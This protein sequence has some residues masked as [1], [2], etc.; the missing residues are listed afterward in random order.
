MLGRRSFGLQSR[1]LGDANGNG[2]VVPGVDLPSG[3]ETLPFVNLNNTRGSLDYT[4]TG[5]YIDTGVRAT[6]ELKV[7]L[8]AKVD[9]VMTGLNWPT[10]L[11]AG[12]YD[13]SPDW[14]QLRNLHGENGPT[15]AFGRQSD[16]D[17]RLLD[18]DKRFDRLEISVD[19]RG[20][21]VCGNLTPFPKNVGTFSCPYSLLLG[22]NRY[23]TRKDRSFRGLIYYCRLYLAD[24]MVRYFVPAMRSSDSVA[25]LYDVVEGV[26][27]PSA[28][29][30]VPFTANDVNV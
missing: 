18:L 22:C 3:Y 20:C 8:A 7:E 26:F 11:G 19:K 1:S 2:P 10:I 23:G 13:N 29:S 4:A 5:A 16:I 12:S 17:C 9:R 28:N 14:V 6:D 15:V 27:Y 24:E 25:G 21:E 30:S